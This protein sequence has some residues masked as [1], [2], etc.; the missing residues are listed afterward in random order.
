VGLQ[1]T[2]IS[3]QL[4]AKAPRQGCNSPLCPYLLLQHSTLSTQH[5]RRP[6]GHAFAECW[7]L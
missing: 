2:A 6:P 1:L 7:E 3:N 4:S 5:N